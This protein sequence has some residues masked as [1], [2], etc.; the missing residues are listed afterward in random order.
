MRFSFTDKDLKCLC[1]VVD[2]ILSVPVMTTGD[3][4]MSLLEPNALSPLQGAILGAFQ[5]IIDVNYIYF[6]NHSILTHNDHCLIL[7]IYLGGCVNGI[8]IQ[9][10]VTCVARTV[11]EVF[12]SGI[13]RL[14]DESG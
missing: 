4:M 3:D 10:D 6:D 2:A 11:V 9:I 8:K 12:V 5:P 7:F 1:D 13:F 14:Q